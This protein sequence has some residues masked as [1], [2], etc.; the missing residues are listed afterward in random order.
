MKE[1]YVDILQLKILD[2]VKITAKN[3]E[4]ATDKAYYMFEKFDQDN[5]D[6]MEVICAECGLKLQEYRLVKDTDNCSCE[7]GEENG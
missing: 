2:R 6:C 7:K 4:E 1:Y 5:Y 3:V